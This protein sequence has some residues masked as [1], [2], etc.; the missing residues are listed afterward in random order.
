VPP[1]LSPETKA[2]GL[3]VPGAQNGFWAADPYGRARLRW[4]DGRR[5]TGYVHD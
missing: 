3:A 1:A 5:W 2:A 4:W